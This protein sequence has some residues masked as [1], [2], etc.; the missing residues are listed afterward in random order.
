MNEKQIREALDACRPGS[1]DLSLP[2]LAPL[3]RT[4]AESTQWRAAFEN[5]RKSDTAIAQALHE[6]AIPAGLEARLLAAVKAAHEA[7]PGGTLPHD[8]A[9]PL[10]HHAGQPQSSTAVSPAKTRHVSR[11]TW[12]TVVATVAATVLVAAWGFDHWRRP[13]AMNAENLGFEALAWSQNLSADWL[14]MSEAKQMNRPVDRQIRFK[15]HGWQLVATSHDATTVAYDLTGTRGTAMLFVLSPA[16][17]PE[18]LSSSAIRIPST[19]GWGVAAWKN[20]DFV[21]VL[22]VEERRQKLDRYLASPATEIALARPV[23]AR[24]PTS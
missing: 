10:Q 5:V 23:I 4:V 11:R 2:D 1:D 19:G 14:D 6:V 16:A 22:L 9:P 3:A 18:A 20:G 15:P 24:S 21:Y 8:L 12:L 13:P 7:Q 17:I